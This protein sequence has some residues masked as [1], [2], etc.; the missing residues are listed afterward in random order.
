MELA[1]FII[2]R[3]ANFPDIRDCVNHTCADGRLCEDGINTY[4]CN[5]SARYTGERCLIGSWEK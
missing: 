4:S 2:D 3:N 1:Y 5:C